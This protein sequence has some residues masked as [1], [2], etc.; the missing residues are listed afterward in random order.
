MTVERIGFGPVP[1][2]R[3]GA[4]LGINNIPPK[5]CSYSCIYCQLGRTD[6]TECE[7]RSFF[8]PK[9]IKEAVERKVKQT[10]DNGGSIDYLTF[11]PDG[12]PTLDENLFEEIRLLRGIGIRI[13]VITN[14][15]LI[16]R[17]DVRDALNRADWVSLK[18]DSV[19]EETWRAINQPCDALQLTRILD[20]MEQFAKAYRGKLVTE[21][22]L[23]EGVNDMDT[24]VEGIAGFLARLKPATAYLS[25]P[26][27]PPAE[28][29]VK[30]PS[31][32]GINRAYQGFRK[33]VKHVECLLGHECGAFGHTGDVAEDLLS[34]TAVHPMREAAVGELLEK[35]GGDWSVVRELIL[36][37]E[38]V[39]QE[40]E[41][42]KFYMR[43]VRG[44]SH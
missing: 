38:L 24:C 39:E 28:K 6:K 3:L 2:R 25:V 12:E 17:A 26:T 21:T 34:I 13:A 43:S 36:Q 31:E 35:S 9:E 4:S 41:G 18:I 40:Y 19:E 16:W 14:G 15:S 29:W 22:I 10:L 8:D 42:T 7:R 30:V 32:G 20:G 1:S 44:R 27:R 33:Q 37:G 11:V 23:V 5:V